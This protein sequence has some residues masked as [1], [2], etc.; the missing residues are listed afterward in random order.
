M[1]IHGKTEAR[2]DKDRQKRDT[3]RQHD[4]ERGG[5]R[6]NDIELFFH[7]ER[8]EMAQAP[9]KIDR[10]RRQVSESQ[11]QFSNGERPV[12]E[13]DRH[14]Q[15]DIRHGQNAKGPADVELLEIDSSGF[16]ALPF[17]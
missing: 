13:E 3:P 10:V 2:S 9:G 7:R 5:Q 17:Q 11:R 12:E 14:N 6:P 1:L 16:M 15:I 8:P 4:A